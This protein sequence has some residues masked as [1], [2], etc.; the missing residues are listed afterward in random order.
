MG[1]VTREILIVLGRELEP[2]AKSR[3]DLIEKSQ[4]APLSLRQVGELK[5][6]SRKN[7]IRKAHPG[8]SFVEVENRLREDPEAQIALK[9]AAHGLGGLPFEK[10]IDTLLE[11]YPGEAQ[12]YADF[13]VRGW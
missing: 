2:L 3:G 1:S 10:A 12:R 5:R 8:W 13:I 4:G 11:E 7:E 6:E 9:F